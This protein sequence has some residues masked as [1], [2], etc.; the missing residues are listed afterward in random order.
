MIVSPVEI[1]QFRHSSRSFYMFV[2]VDGTCVFQL[3]SRYLYNSTRYAQCFYMFHEGFRMTLPLH[4]ECLI[5]IGVDWN[6]LL[7]WMSKWSFKELNEIYH[8]VRSNL[9]LAKPL[10]IVNVAYN[11][12]V[13]ERKP[14]DYCGIDIASVWFGH[15]FVL[16]RK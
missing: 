14:V 4:L 3:L 15:C 6:T 13:K 10:H 9:L 2:Y 7:R 16:C 5:P 8:S 1:L 11:S 12:F